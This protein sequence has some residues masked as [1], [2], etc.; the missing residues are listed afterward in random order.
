MASFGNFL[1][2]ATR[3]VW[4]RGF[5][6]PPL[7]PRT[8]ND[9]YVTKMVLFMVFEGN[10]GQEARVVGLWTLYD[11]SYVIIWTFHFDRYITPEVPLVTGSDQ[12]CCF[13]C[14]EC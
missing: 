10:L 13:L 9:R 1:W 2:N 4:G 14:F 8:G 6:H 7:T 12:N 3:R 5:C 11:D